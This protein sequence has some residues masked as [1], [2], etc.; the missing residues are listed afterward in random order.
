LCTYL[1]FH[2]PT[3]FTLALGTFVLS[4][5]DAHFTLELLRRGATEV[6]VFM[7]ALMDRSVETF[8]WTKLVLTGVSVVFLVA[9]ERIRLLNRVR[10]ADILAGAFGIYALLVCYE[11]FLL[12]LG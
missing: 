11:L 6:N 4:M 12:N 2:S 8:I 10:V 3:L 5:A 9:H 1:D 7:V